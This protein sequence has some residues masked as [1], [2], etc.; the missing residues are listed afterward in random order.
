MKKY[1]ILMT[2]LAAVSVCF[3][4]GEESVD[5]PSL[6]GTEVDGKS[7]ETETVEPLT[8]YLRP[9]L[10][11]GKKWIV[12]YIRTPTLNDMVRTMTVAG[13]TIHKGYD[14]KVAKYTISDDPGHEEREK[15]YREEDGCLYQYMEIRGGMNSEGDF[16]QDE[17]WGALW[18]LNAQCG[19][20]FGPEYNNN[21]TVV[22]RGTIVLMGKT[23]RAVKVY[24]N[25]YRG[26]YQYDFI[27]EGIGPLFGAEPSYEKI[28]PT[29]SSV[30]WIRLLEC[31]DGDE[32]IYDYEEFDA[33]TYVPETFYEGFE[34]PG[35]SGRD[36]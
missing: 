15:I 1:A 32:K 8:D 35:Y 7:E 19:D 25:Y 6:S 20:V 29:G 4:C 3:S 2:I 9:I 13:D 24:C 17:I 22:G 16:T 23:R 18:D 36:F 34:D 12:E 30:E 26:E 31:Y 33:S 27:V 28:Q 21:Y 14:A 10:T 5:D 11:D